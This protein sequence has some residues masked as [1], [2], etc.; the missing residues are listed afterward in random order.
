MAYNEEMRVI[1]VGDDDQNI[2]SFRGSDSQ[3]LRRFTKIKDGKTYELLANYRSKKNIVGFANQFV[4]KIE[5]RLKAQPILPHSKENGTIKL[6]HYRSTGLVVPLV[7]DL[8]QTPLTGTTCVLTQTNEQAELAMSLLITNQ[9]QARLIQSNDHFNLLNLQEIRYF[10]DEL[11]VDN[12][13]PYISPEVWD[14]AKRALHRKYKASPNFDL[15]KHII[16]DFQATNR[17]HKYKTDLRIFIKES[18][19]EDF[20]RA[21][22]E[23]IYVSTMHKSKGKE[24][25]NVILLLDHFDMSRD[26]AKRLVYV[27][28]TRAKNNL[29]IHINGSYFN[30]IEVP[31]LLKVN[32]TNTYSPPNSLLLRTGL[33]DVNLGFFRKNQVLIRHLTTGLKLKPVADG[34]MYQN[35]LVAKYSHSFQQALGKK[36]RNGYQIYEANISH[37]VYWRDIKTKRQVYT[38]LIGGEMVTASDSG[39]ILVVLVDIWLIKK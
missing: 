19:M 15:A 17:K 24:F 4:L 23:L 31:E 33:K 16:K 22:N 32:S 20:L 5:N 2:F 36:K 34:L 27:A 21:N 14:T 13:L 6:F 7:E 39:E 12:D 26:E 11:K 25:D 10:L 3:Y 37:L 8:K 29:T 38:E 30:Q 28:M 9:L 1:I 35:R 18:K